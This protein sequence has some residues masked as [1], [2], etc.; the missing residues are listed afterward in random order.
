MM[1]GHVLKLVLKS[2]RWRIKYKKEEIHYQCKTC[3]F[4]T[5]Q[6]RKLEMHLAEKYDEKFSCDDCGFSGKTSYVFRR[7]V[8]NMHS[9]IK[10]Q[11]SLELKSD[12]VHGK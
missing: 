7:H 5:N 8:E 9:S 6:E 12:F 4:A 11:S 3:K 10:R 2:W 1:T